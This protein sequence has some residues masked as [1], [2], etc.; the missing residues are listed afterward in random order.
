MIALLDELIEIHG[1]NKKDRRRPVV[2]RKMVVSKLF[3]D[4]GYTY[5]EIGE[6]LNLNHATVLYYLKNYAACKAYD[7]DFVK[8][9]ADILK[10]FTGPYDERIKLSQDVARL[11][12]E[13]KEAKLKLNVFLETIITKKPKP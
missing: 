8:H 12:K 1:L 6:K 9:E 2:H 13:L 3:R 5:Q 4:I 7:V 11:E 10:H